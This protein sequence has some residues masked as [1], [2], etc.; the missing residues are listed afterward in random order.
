MALDAV[1]ATATLVDNATPAAARVMSSVGQVSNGYRL[2]S[3][4]V[5]ANGDVLRS[6][7]AVATQS[8]AK[9]A[10]ATAAQ[11]KS[12]GGA[13]N[14]FDV[15][16]KGADKFISKKSAIKDVLA[17]SM[18]SSVSAVKDVGG[19]LGFVAGEIQSVAGTIGRL[20][21]AG[22]AA[23]YGLKA[24]VYAATAGAVALLAMA[25]AAV[26]VISARSQLLATF[27]ALSFGATGGAKTLAIVEKLGT[28]LPQSTAKIAEWATELQKTGFQGRALESALKAVAAAEALMGASGAAAAQ[29]L[30]N[31]L[32]KGGA[33]AAS[34]IMKI[35]ANLPEAREMLA[36]MG[37]RIEDIAGA[38]GM[39]LP[40]FRAAKL[41]AKQMAEAVEKA[42]ARKAAGPLADLMLTFPSILGKAKEGMLSLFDKL[43]PAVKPF[44]GAVKKLFGEFSKGGSV[45][46]FL[47]PIVT[48]VMTTLFTWGA[49]A[50]GVV[51]SIVVWLASAGKAGGF[52]SGAIAVMKIGWAS[53]VGIFKV[54]SVALR[55]VIGLLKMIFSNAMVLSGIKTI[56]TVIAAVVTG[57]VVA[58]VG[59]VA[60]MSTVIGFFGGLVGALAGIPAAMAGL[61]SSIINGLIGGITGGAGGFISSLM[62]MA[63]SGLAAFKGVFGIA[64][65][66]KVMAEMGGHVAGGAE[67]GIDDGSAKVQKSMD[68]MMTPKGAPAGKG[69]KGGA[70]VVND[71]RGSTFTGCTEA[72]VDQWMNAWWSRKNSEAMA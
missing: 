16:T 43:G 53:L 32:G 13:K 22:A 6:W 41:S 45:I 10:A 64:S 39:T 60:V 71:F 52:F 19:P 34:L 14:P 30:L 31:S 2:M 38:L 47:K 24:I 3:E 51:R 9:V 11:N 18:A 58:F 28:Q 63:S 25:A 67:Q 50:V 35:K 59:I 48:S 62:A 55:P 23:A 72:D 29:G 21:P 56:F 54:V 66:S 57:L 46:T 61:A 65:P 15:A 7:S 36:S 4:S 49:K 44:M 17:G 1:R 33:E 70:G 37:L 27:G 26:M 40:Q 20:G 69:A 8:T 5:R 42:L 68:S 12:D